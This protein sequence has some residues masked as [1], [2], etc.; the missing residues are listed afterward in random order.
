[1]H[2]PHILQHTSNHYTHQKTKCLQPTTPI[3][4]QNQINQDPLPHVL[5]FHHLPLVLVLATPTPTQR[6]P[7][8]CKTQK[9]LLEPFSELRKVWWSCKLCLSMLSENK[10][11]KVRLA[12]FIKVIEDV[13]KMSCLIDEIC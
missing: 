7:S 8:L 1:M 4:P 13:F 12:A 10:T 2:I 3:N 11:T 5:K 9:C 6:Q